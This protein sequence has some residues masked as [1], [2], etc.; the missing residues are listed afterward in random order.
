MNTEVI[1]S[2]ENVTPLALV[3]GEAFLNLPK[4]LYIPPDAMRVFLEAFEGPL[5][6]LLYLIKKQNLDILNIPIAEVTRQYMEYVE[7]MKS[8][9]LE[10]AAEYLVMAAV[11]AEIKSRLLLPRPESAEVEE[12]DPRAELIRRLQ[13]YERF[14]LAAEKLD[15]LPRHGRDTFV[16]SATIQEITFEKPKPEVSLDEILQAFMDVMRR[17]ELTVHHQIQLEA[18]SVRDRMTRILAVLQEKEF[19]LFSSLFSMNEGKI[20]VVVTFLAMLELL[21]DNLIEFVQT[22][23][24]GPIHLKANTV[25]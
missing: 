16:A 20:G 19:A 2:T 14:K 17:A 25:N 3:Q 11:L 24:F 1:V 12:E 15:E 23:A 18:L 13:E 6:L 5:D 9:S 22:K 7:L 8:I 21:K 10:L 4:D